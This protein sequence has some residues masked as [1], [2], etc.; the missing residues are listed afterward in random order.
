M[1]PK[2]FNADALKLVAT[3]DERADL[4]ALLSNTDLAHLGFDVRGLID[5]LII[6]CIKRSASMCEAEGIIVDSIDIS[7]T[8]GSDIKAIKVE[9]CV[10]IRGCI[11]KSD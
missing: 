1:I 7:Y 8:F 11:K 2:Q 9:V 6:R 3:R 5:R 10:T 4:D